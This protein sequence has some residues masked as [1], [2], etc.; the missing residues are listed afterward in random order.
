MQLDTILSS[1]DTYTINVYTSKTPIGLVAEDDLVIGIVFTVDLI[2]AVE[3]EIDI[4]SGF[5]IQLID[6]IAINVPIFNINVSSVTFI[7]GSFEILSMT[8]KN[9][10]VILT[11]I[12]RIE[13]CSVKVSTGIE[14]GVWVDIVQFKTNITAAPATNGNTCELRVIEKYVMALE[15]NTGA[16]LAIG[17]TPGVLSLKPTPQSTTLRSQRYALQ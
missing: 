17:L 12:L 7:G 3:T 1:G 13:G 6:G 10:G 8:I 9:A 5:H 4:S 15:A 2:I 11:A 14:A 16:A